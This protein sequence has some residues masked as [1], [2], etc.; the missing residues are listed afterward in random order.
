[1]ET[2]QTKTRPSLLS[3]A[4]R[5]DPETGYPSLAALSKANALRIL[6]GVITELT[7]QGND[8]D[9]VTLLA[10]IDE[11]RHEIWAELILSSSEPNAMEIILH[12][13]HP[14]E[15]NSDFVEG[16]GIIEEAL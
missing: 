5:C 15:E 2:H 9:S 14:S 13:E 1:M 4:N 11:N 16:G 6:A 10:G 12:R 7:A 8:G 3:P